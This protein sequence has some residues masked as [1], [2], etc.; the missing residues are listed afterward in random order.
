MAT[1]FSESIGLCSSYYASLCWRGLRKLGFAG[2]EPEPGYAGW[3]SRL[4]RVGSH[5]SFAAPL[6]GGPAFTFVY[7]IPGS[8]DPAGPANLAE[9]ADFLEEFIRHK[10]VTALMRR[11]PERT[12]YWDQWY[13]PG[14]MVYLADGREDELIGLVR[15]FIEFLAGEWEGYREEHEAKLA[16]Y[17]FAD[18]AAAAVAVE[19]MVLWDRELGMP[20]PYDRFDLV[21]CPESRTLASSLGPERVVFGAMHDWPA[22]RDAIVHEVGVRYLSI[23][24]LRSHPATH[25]LIARDFGGVIRLVETEVCYRKPRLLPDLDPSADPFMKGMRLGELVAWRRAKQ[26]PSDFFGTLPEWYADARSRGLL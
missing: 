25:D 12:R 24:R 3:S 19:P 1:L 23:G 2:G 16:G 22:M 26:D 18:R 15:L 13:I 10:D 14:S 21:I 5:F 17:P 4:S 9:V 7:Q 8:L 6:A 11:W 20:Y